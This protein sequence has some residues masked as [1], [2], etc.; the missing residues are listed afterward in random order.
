MYSHWAVISE[1]AA[2]FVRGPGMVA[3]PG[4]EGPGD[5]PSTDAVGDPCVGT[6]GTGSNA[7]GMGRWASFVEGTTD[8]PVEGFVCNHDTGL[9]CDFDTCGLGNYCD[10]SVHACAPRLEVGAACAGNLVDECAPVA[11]CDPTTFSCTEPLAV[12]Q[13]CS[14]ES[15][16]PAR[17]CQSGVCSDGA[18]VSALAPLCTGRP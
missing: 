14:E 1:C 10:F 17:Q 11:F 6:T 4:P 5:L 8:P 15:A 7:D 12:G 18:C 9:V 2:V 13:A 3:V 16:A